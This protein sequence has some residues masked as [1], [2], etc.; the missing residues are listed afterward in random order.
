L[1][2][3]TAPRELSPIEKATTIADLKLKIATDALTEAR[4]RI[5]SQTQNYGPIGEATNFILNL[6]SYPH[7]TLVSKHES[8]IAS[9]ILQ[10]LCAYMHQR[11]AIATKAPRDAVLET[12]KNLISDAARLYAEFTVETEGT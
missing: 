10:T 9:R 6:F 5:D 3:P 1:A 7:N 4:Q 11:G 2:N 8:E 12:L